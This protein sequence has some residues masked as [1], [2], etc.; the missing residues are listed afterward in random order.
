MN[1]NTPFKKIEFDD[2]NTR[3]QTCNFNLSGKLILYCENQNNKEQESDI[4]RVYSIQIT[5]KCQKVYMMPK[6]AGVISISKH[7]KIRFNFNEHV[8]EW[9]KSTGTT[10]VIS[11]NRDKVFR[12]YFSQELSL[13]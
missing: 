4:V 11:T 6:E 1:T 3:I 7:D 5:V 9:N 2:K 8:Y 10:K 12:F 13:F